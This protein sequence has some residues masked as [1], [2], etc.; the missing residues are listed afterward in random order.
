MK[1]PLRGVQVSECQVGSVVLRASVHSAREISLRL[2][3]FSTVASGV[4]KEEKSRSIVLIQ[5][6]DFRK[7]VTSRFPLAE[8]PLQVSV[9]RKRSDIRRRERQRF[10]QVLVCRV[11]VAK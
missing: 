3:C 2:L 4:S 6:E 7:S 10:F 1:V 8:L 5:R 9:A 11:Q